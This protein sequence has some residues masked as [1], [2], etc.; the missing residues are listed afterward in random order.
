MKILWKKKNNNKNETCVTRYSTY[1]NHLS[2]MFF[3]VN[4]LQA[5][6]ANGSPLS[7]AGAGSRTLLFARSRSVNAPDSV[8]AVLSDLRRTAG[9]KHT[10]A[11]APRTMNGCSAEEINRDCESHVGVSPRLYVRGFNRFSLLTTRYNTPSA[12][13]GID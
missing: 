2:S 8:E 10:R 6:F 4:G 11:A 7:P 1:G 13:R 12:S 5:A 9:C 3:A